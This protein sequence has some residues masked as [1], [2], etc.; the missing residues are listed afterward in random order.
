M[1]N[2]KRLNNISGI[3]YN[4]L[5][6][7][8]YTVSS[9]VEDAEA[10]AYLV[11]SASCHEIEFAPTVKAIARAGAGV[12]N[13]PLDKC[14]EQGIVV[15]NTPGANANA[16]KELVICAILMASRNVI[17]GNRWAMTLGDEGDNILKV[18]EKGKSQFVGPEIMGKTLGVIG[19]G[20]IGALVANAAEN[21]GMN[22]IGYDPMISVENAWLL[23]AGVKR[24]MVLDELLEK[25]DYITIHVPL[26]PATKNIIS[27]HEFSKMKDNTILLNF[28][29]NGLVD[30]K[31]LAE[32]FETGKVSKYVVDFPEA[33]ILDNPKVIAVPHLGASTPES[34]ENCAKMAAIEL[35]DFLE[36]G[37]INNSVNMPKCI[38]SDTNLHRV[39][40]FH[41]NLPKQISQMTTIFANEHINVS[42]MVNKSRGTI[43]YSVFDLDSV[44]S[45]EA[46]R[47]IEA[48]DGVVKVREIK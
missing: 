2:I 36:T 45:E 34:E 26:L 5:S 28:A 25:A 38:L 21:L 16:V 39:A 37:S 27:Y 23:S 24:A 3:V 48:I 6:K 18:I 35:R 31:A 46:I 12:N 11:R 15:F 9:H 20:A 47:A 44:P 32:A 4:Y 29:R 41:Q 17:E 7:E 40:V 33:D 13:I 19:L 14:T 42:E 1:F 8:K 22:V 30:K 43:A 10:D